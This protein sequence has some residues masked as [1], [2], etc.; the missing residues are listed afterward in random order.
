MT[1]IDLHRFKKKQ[2]YLVFDFETES[3]NL[4]FSRPWQVAFHILEGDKIIESHDYFILWDNLN[5]S[6]DAAVATRFSLKTYR[7]KAQEPKKVLKIIE[8]FI[9]DDS[10]ILIGHN[11]LGFDIY[12]H[13]TWRRECGLK[14]DY[15]YINRLIDTNC[16][17][18]AIEF[19]IPLKE[20]EN[21]LAFQYRLLNKKA[22]GVKTGID[23]CCKKY[24]IPVDPQKRHQ[25][26]YDVELNGIIWNKQKWAFEI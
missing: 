4:F 2:K 5:V 24:N 25:A 12:Q 23:A 14:S 15:S 7:E 21:R 17:E 16:I 11:I 6:R 9:Y 10:F 26:L 18:K 13:N 3:L 22:K 1:G 8:D 20:N 19:N